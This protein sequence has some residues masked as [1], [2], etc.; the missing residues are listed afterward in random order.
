MMEEN[1]E[2]ILNEIRDRVH[3][4]EK[5]LQTEEDEEANVD[6]TLQ[7]LEDITSVPRAEMEH[8]AAEIRR[9][10]TLQEQGSS[11]SSNKTPVEQLPATVRE[12]YL[13]LPPVLQ[14]EFWEVVE[15]EVGG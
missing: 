11:P 3:K 8:I 6:A 12:A 9:M 14:D 1:Q 4:R 2:E 5:E 10:H 7:A 13:K 15:Q